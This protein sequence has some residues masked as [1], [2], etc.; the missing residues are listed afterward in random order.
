[1]KRL[2]VF[3]MVLAILVILSKTHFLKRLP[4]LT[5]REIPLGSLPA[6]S[7]EGSP[8]PKLRVENFTFPESRLNHITSIATTEEGIWFGSFEGGLLRF[9]GEKWRHFTTEEGL[10]D[11]EVNHLAS[12]GKVL[13]I[14][15]SRGISRF[16]GRYFR[17]FTSKDG[18]LHPHIT[19]IL[20]D[21]EVVW[22]G[23][24]RGVMRYK[25]GTF[26]SFTPKDGLISGHVY[27]LTK[28]KGMLWVGTLKGL[29]CFDGE[30]WRSYQDV[31]GVISHNWINAIASDNKTL[32]VGTYH[33][34]LSRLEDGKWQIFRDNIPSLWIN[35]NAIL[36]EC[37]RVWFG[38]LGDGLMSYN[39]G[40]W[41]IYTTKEGLVGD[42]VTALA[43]FKDSLWVGTTS[44]VSR[45][46][47]KR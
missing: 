16:D 18:L 12:T 21:E 47:L 35:P 31:D 44:G 29:A 41:T 6:N 17:N 2:L 26:T 1:M 30:K 7:W 8:P 11:N 4:L 40:K 36:I 10:V 28:H 19:S 3:P 25:N 14:G 33:R 46:E 24:P 45:L 23:T 20:I 39:E 13:W 9:D 15:T 32:W 27:T 22:F 42:N 38:T 37:G 5:I 43:K 34:G